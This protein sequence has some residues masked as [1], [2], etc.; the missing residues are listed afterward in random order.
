LVLERDRGRWAVEWSPATIHPELRSTSRFGV[1]RV[2]VGREPILAADGTP[3]AGTGEQVTFGF[4]PALVEDDEEVVQAFEAALAGSGAAARRELSRSNLNPAWFYP[5]VT[6]GA[7]RA[8]AASAR[9][10]EAAGILRRS[11]G[12]ARVL[13]DDDFARHLVGIV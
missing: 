9:L 8:D 2:E 13:H 3:L 11:D 5:V 4:Q 6:V 7:A 1:Q 12:T 10:R